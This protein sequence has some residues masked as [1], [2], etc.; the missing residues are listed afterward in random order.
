MAELHFR[1]VEVIDS[2]AN[3]IRFDLPVRPLSM[4][5]SDLSLYEYVDTAPAGPLEDSLSMC[6]PPE[7][8][9]AAKKEA[10]TGTD[11]E[12]ESD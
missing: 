7:P 10:D 4:P 1:E 8:A 5:F 9:R 3:A 6:L 12:W 11:R 2:N